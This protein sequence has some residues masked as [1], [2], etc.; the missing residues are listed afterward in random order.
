[1][2]IR[3]GIP[4]YAEFEACKPGLAE[5]RDCR[6]HEFDV[7]PR[8]GTYI[9]KTR[10]SFINDLKSTKAWQKPL[11]YDAFLDI[12]SDISFTLDDVLVMIAHNKDCISL[13]YLRQGGHDEYECGL[14][15]DI[16]GSLGGYF[17]PKTK[18]LRKVDWS[19]G[20]MRLTKAHVYEVMA[21]PW[22]F[23]PM[24]IKGD[25]QE[26]GSEDIGFCMNV[27]KAGFDIWMDFDR[28]VGHKLRTPQQFNWSIPMTNSS[29]D[30]SPKQ[31]AEDISSTALNV[32]KLTAIMAENYSVAVEEVRACHNLIREQAQKIKMLEESL[33]KETAPKGTA[34]SAS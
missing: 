20:G 12:D 32:N 28:P 29:Q 18:G 34:K 30:N 15:K 8:Q 21:Y 13:P 7:Q 11:P 25:R 10:N 4:F 14:W 17:T 9:G 19:G 27:A 24:I 16:P 6:E 2:R 1:M 5:L 23:H 26:E 31:F 3:V 22:Y 33:K